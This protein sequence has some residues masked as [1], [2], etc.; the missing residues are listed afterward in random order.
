MNKAYKI[1]EEMDK[2]LNI[3]A[4]EE[5]EMINIVLEIKEENN[6]PNKDIAEY[7]TEHIVEGIICFTGDKK[8]I[9]ELINEILEE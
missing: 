6:L 2:K 5:E 9:Y 3:S 7:L 8:E 1:V 4:Y